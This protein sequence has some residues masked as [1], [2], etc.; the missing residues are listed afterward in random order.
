VTRS[1]AAGIRFRRRI[2]GRRY[3]WSRRR[4][5]SRAS[6]VA[7]ALTGSLGRPNGRGL[8]RALFPP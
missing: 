3:W 4:L 6:R 8:G 7:L 1:A 5:R 2:R